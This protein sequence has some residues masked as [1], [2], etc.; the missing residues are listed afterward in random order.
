LSGEATQRKT[1]N[2]PAVRPAAAAPVVQRRIAPAP[3]VVQTLSKISSPKDPAEKEAEATAKKIMR[4]AAPVSSA[5][6]PRMQSPYVARFAGSGVFAQRKEEGQPSISSN[7]A[8]DIRSSMSGG[9]PLPPSVRGFMEPRFRADFSKVKVH[10][11]EKAARLSTQLSAQAFTVGSHVFFGRDRFRPESSEG[12]ELI[13]HELTHTIQQGGAVQRSED[14]SVTQQSSEQVQ[15]LS[16]GDVADRL[17][18][19]AN[20]IPGFRMFTIVL[21]VNPINMSRVDRSAANILRAVVEFIPGGA[22]ITQALD[23]Y[24]VFDRVGSWV[25]QQIRT[26]G[27]TGASIRQAIEDFV[28]PLGLSDIF[29]LGDVL[30]RA[31]RI[32]TDPIDR[33]ISFARN[34]GAGILRFIREAILRPLARLAER[35]QGYDLLK[36]V[37]GQD[38]ITG[39]PVPRTADTLI[40]GFMKLIGQEEVWNNLKRANAVARA[41]AWFQ[42]ALGE[43]MGFVRQV[44][45]LFLQA[46]QELE[47][48]DI[49]LLPR[50]FLRVG[51]AFAGFIG[52]F[53]SW[54]GA[55]V[56]DLL[57]IIFEVLAPAAVPYL[58]RAAGAFRTIIQNP[59]GFL[60]NL[61]R[62]ALQG[63]RQ[64]GANFLTHLRASLIGWLTG[65]MSGANIYIP[66]GFNLREII[67]FVL[68]VLGLTWQNIRQ[69]LV[70]VVGETAVR[71]MET[72]FDIVMTL[73]TQGPAAA[74]EKI[75]ESLSNL[76]EMVMEQIMTFVRDRVV[77]AA[78]TR[79]LSM[80]SPAGAFIQAIIAIYNTI[81]F[82]VER[83]RQI[84]QVAAAFIDSISAIASGVI[85]AAANRVE[86][87][88]AGLLTLVISFLARIAGL[89]RVSDAVTNVINR[90][91]APIDRAL[92]RVVD[93]IVAQ[94]R[95]L[96]RFIAQAGVPQDP[97]ERLRLGMAAAVAAA[98]RFARRPVAKPVLEGLLAAIKV[99]YGFQLLEPRERGP[100]WSVY[101]V[102]N[103]TVGVDT[104]AD[105]AGIIPLSPLTPAE[106]ALIRPIPGG[107]D[108]LARLAA[109]VARRATPQEIAGETA[110]LR[111]ALQL[112]GG[113]ATLLYIGLNVRRAGDV[114]TRTE[115]DILTASEMIEVKTRDYGADDK[116]SGP[117]MTQFSRLRMIFKGTLKVVDDTGNAFRPPPRWVY[118]F[119]RP[120]SPALYNWLKARDVTEV[121]TAV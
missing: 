30:S 29:R 88:M 80:L 100:K 24:G 66:Q 57:Q 96:G 107:M 71:A 104:D 28:R 13:A 17:A 75:Q 120:I 6:P 27:I 65:A 22:L 1:V 4:M 14:V 115:I 42:G 46:L 117:D 37:L 68:S 56:L 114:R 116:L 63:F 21:G 111:T 36:A 16:L 39:D 119:T 101:G 118:Q 33:I 3:A 103:P 60:G 20:A 11:G 106:E 59:I 55:K 98:N 79:L 43:L 77:T 8:A 83:L 58:R 10:T 38:P 23:N 94:A 92:D 31:R 51:R 78:I 102:V 41:W 112:L 32:F 89:G 35:T 44:P 90:V 34:L 121:R 62:A 91:R 87:T 40:G 52:R 54:A 74:W 5:T 19:W 99:R 95:R 70:R 64:F 61:V 108:Q 53:I 67:K 82:F 49:V 12:R 48:A 109:T 86:Q 26:L 50:A 113:G 2:R 47:I 18:G 25:E 81:M 76:R 7:A 84:A 85:A 93:W 69:K 9:S 110:P 15:R 72:G 45:T 73:V 97:N 105:V